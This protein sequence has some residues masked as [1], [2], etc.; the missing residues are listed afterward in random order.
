M[1]VNVA[2]AVDGII[3][4]GMAEKPRTT[5]HEDRYET[6]K[7]SESTSIILLFSVT[8]TKKS[9]LLR[10]IQIYLSANK[11]NITTQKNV[12]MEQYSREYLIQAP[13][14]TDEETG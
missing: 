10:Q 11:F 9:F 7:N 1:L 13:H 2:W 3:R 12:K 6:G 8:T 14:W 5:F 4:C